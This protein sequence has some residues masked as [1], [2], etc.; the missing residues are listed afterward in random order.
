MDERIRMEVAT[1]R[2]G[3]IADFVT[4]QKFAHGGKLRLLLE[5]SERHYSRIP[6]SC[7]TRISK[8]TILSWIRLYQVGGGRIESL[9][10]QR[11][12]DKGSFRALSDELQRDLMSLRQ[13]DSKMT[14]P[15]MLQRL[16]AEKLKDV[17]LSTVYRFL[18]QYEPVASEEPDADRRRFEV[19]YPNQL[20]QCDV[21]HGPMVRS[22]SGSLKKSYLFGIMDDHSRLVV[23][24]QFF[25][26]ENLD[27]LKECLKQAVESRGLPQKFYV[28]NGACY[29]AGNL[30]ECLARLGISIAHSRPYVPQGRGKIERWFR[31]VRQSFIPIHADRPLLLEEIN[32]RLAKWI[33]EYNSAPHGTTKMSPYDRFRRDMSCVRPAPD[34]LIEYFRMIERR[35]VRKDRTVQFNNIV[36]E[37][38]IGLIDRQVELHFHTSAPDDIEVFFEK[39]SYGK[40]VPLNLVLNSQLGRA[41]LETKERDQEDVLTPTQ[42]EI[43]S[44]ELFGGR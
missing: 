16:G 31:Y 30:E 35:R 42:S 38:P 37:V 2:F 40:A 5:K 33:H 26:S 6:G 39:R 43:R 18:A 10:P 25:L 8:A 34:N 41:S 4:G 19:E 14:L 32:E 11:R 13:R 17:H 44:G 23:H 20:W 3:V 21:M 7:R 9:M 24:G 12:A 29:R 22:S 28:D 27:A 1:F 36:Y 15:V